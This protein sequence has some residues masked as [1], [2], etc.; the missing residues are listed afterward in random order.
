M[1]HLDMKCN[2]YYIEYL[3]VFIITFT[4][5]LER[6]VYHRH[7]Q[8]SRTQPEKYVTIIIDGMDQKK[9]SLPFLPRESKSAQVRINFASNV[10]VYL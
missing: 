2:I 1:N 5:R 4:S 6:S 7:I 3:H 8:K 10:Q 9:T